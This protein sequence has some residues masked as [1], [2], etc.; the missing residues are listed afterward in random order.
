VQGVE[1]LSRGFSAKKQRERKYDSLAS[2]IEYK[3]SRESG[4]CKV[5][6]SSSSP[7][8]LLQ[9]P[10]PTFHTFQGPAPLSQ[11]SFLLESDLVSLASSFNS[12]FKKH[13]LN[14]NSL[15]LLELF[16]TILYKHNTAK[17]VR[18]SV[19]TVFTCKS[20]K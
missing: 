1:T 5:G 20:T 16:I 4:P 17:M 9:S 6:L 3:K 15:F 10:T 14:N 12:L 7:P 13:E 18:L 2:S 19:A 8:R 11:L